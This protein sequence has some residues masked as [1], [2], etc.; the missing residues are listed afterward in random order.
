MLR[1]DVS[2]MA[3]GGALDGGWLYGAVKFN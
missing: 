1:T 2:S 3:V